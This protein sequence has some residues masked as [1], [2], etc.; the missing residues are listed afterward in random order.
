MTRINLVHPSELSTRHLVAEYREIVRVFAL[1][2][3][4]QHTMHK[5]KLPKEYTL[6]AGHVLFFYDKLNFISTRYDSLCEEMN[7]RKFT[8]NRVPRESLHEGIGSHMFFN[9]VPTPEAIKINRQRIADR[10]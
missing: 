2:R 5:R 4:S 9:Y 8:C 7:K 1:A 10:S 3:K 6:G